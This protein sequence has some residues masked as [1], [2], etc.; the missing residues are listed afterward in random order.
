[1]RRQDKRVNGDED[2]KCKDNYLKQINLW[3]SGKWKRSLIF[4][5]CVPSRYLNEDFGTFSTKK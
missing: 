1:M 4:S 3:G 2:G 5:K